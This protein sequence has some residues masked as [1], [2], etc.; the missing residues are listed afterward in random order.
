MNR[1]DYVQMC[2]EKVRELI[3]NREILIHYVRD[4]KGFPHT[5]GVISKKGVACAKH[6]PIDRYNK[7]VGIYTAWKRGQ[8]GV[9]HEFDHDKQ[10]VALCDYLLV[11]GSKYFKKLDFI[12]SQSQLTK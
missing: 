6:N 5:V 3:N 1:N 4:K 7:Y 10:V 11:R 2:R 9:F 12:E 8:N